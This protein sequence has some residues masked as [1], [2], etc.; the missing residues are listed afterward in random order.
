MSRATLKAIQA[1][2]GNAGEAVYVDDVFSTYL[3]EGNGTSD[4]STNQIQNGLDLNGEGGLV[5]IKKRSGG[6]TGKSHTLVDSERGDDERFKSETNDA[7]FTGYDGFISFNS[8]G[9]TV[10]KTGELQNANGRPYVSW[11]FRKQPGFFDVVAYTGTGSA[12]TVS[13]NLG[14]VPG[15]IIVKRRDST[16]GWRVY[17]RGVDATAPEDFYLALNSND[18]RSN[19]NT[20]WNDTAPTS[21]EFTIGT[22]T[23]VNASGGSYIAYL[24]AH[25]AQD[26]GTDSDESIIKCGS[27]D[28]TSSTQDIELGFEPQWLLIKSSQYGGSGDNP[29]WIIVDMMREMSDSAAVRLTPNS[30][31]FESTNTSNKFVPKPTGFQ[32]QASGRWENESGYS[33]VYVAIRRPQKPASEFAATDLFD[34]DTRNGVDDNAI[35]ITGVNFPVDAAL[36]T[37]TN[38]QEDRAIGARLT[39]K[40]ALFTN[41]SGSQSTRFET[42]GW[43]H[44][45][46]VSVLGDLNKNTYSYIDYFFR[47]APGFFDV[48]TYTG[49]GSARTINHNLNAVP[50]LMLVKGRN[51]AF[52]WDVYA[53]PL[54]NTKKLS[55]NSNAVPNTSSTYWNSTTPTESVFSLGTALSNNNNGSTFINYLFA[56][57][58]GISKVGSYTGTGANLDV[59]CGFT[60]GARFVLVKRTD[61]TGDWYVWDSA[62]GIT[63]GNDPYL[64][65]NSNQPQTTGTDYIDPLSSGFTVTSSAPAA[66]NASGGTYIFLAIA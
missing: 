18:A 33:Y 48:V 5:W 24:F 34:L 49:T 44:Q 35:D 64:L 39:G 61:S 66:L 14:S 8:D 4:S 50:Q 15:M 56:T 51:A 2:A 65:L 17:H 29:Y 20:I 7:S 32:I 58:P 57:A 30:D 60:S 63:A 23:S 53:D 11:S 31:D 38:Q 37:S 54:G 46:G 13:H 9:F 36:I 40:N 45:D 43:D 26:F 47:R 6:S 41:T 19:D 55:L 1:A 10:G 28:G 12:K 21:T 25:D 27:Y 62:R 16:G 42:P 22:A 52:S 59:D 3:Y